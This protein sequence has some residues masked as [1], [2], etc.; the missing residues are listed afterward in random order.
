MKTSSGW[1]RHLSFVE[2]HMNVKY[3][4][5]GGPD[6]G[7]TSMTL[8]EVQI[9]V[10]SLTAYRVCAFQCAT[11]LHTPGSLQ[12]AVPKQLSAAHYIN[13]MNSSMMLM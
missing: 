2:N 8:K 5:E 11:S 7:S 6:G 3:T 12:I 10:I 1:T 13:S 4:D 9:K